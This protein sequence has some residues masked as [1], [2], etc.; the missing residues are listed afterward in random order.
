MTNEHDNTSPVVGSRTYYPEHWGASLILLAGLGLLVLGAWWAITRDG[1]T[2]FMVGA[3]GLLGLI[4]AG[5]LLAPSRAFLHLGDDG[6]TYSLFFNP[7][8][9][10]WSDIERFG[11]VEWKGFERIA[12]DYA[13]HY[14]ADATARQQSKA[15][16]G[17][18]MILPLRLRKTPT[19]IVQDLDRR[20][21][22][23]RPRSGPPT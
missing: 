9:I 12:W 8:R 7:K 17:H 19:Q 6:L 14:P 16:F 1:S 22:A 5:V 18:E 3:V 20:L 15:A 21:E 2:G 23:Y 4:V 13:P 10:P 11:L